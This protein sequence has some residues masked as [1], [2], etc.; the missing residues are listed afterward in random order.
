MPQPDLNSNSV[1]QA[2]TLTVPISSGGITINLIFDNGATNI[3]PASFRAGIEQAAT[4]LAAAITDKITVNIRVDYGGVAHGGALGGPDNTFSLS[5]SDVRADLINHAAP[6]DTTFNA[7]PAGSSIQG[8]TNVDV[9]GAQAKLWGLL[10][11][12]DTTTDDGITIFAQDIDP[13]LLAGTALHELTHALGRVPDGPQPDVFDP[14]R[15]TSPGVRLFQVYSTEFPA[16]PAYF[17]VD[18]GIT[19]LADYGQSC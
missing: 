17:S 1:V 3:A 9:F 19:K 2:S 15:F 11:A 8:Q 18:G 13:A 4:L 7:L 14:F 6:G 5:Y 16:P 12:N 10:G